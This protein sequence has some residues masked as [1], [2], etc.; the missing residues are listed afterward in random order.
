MNRNKACKPLTS[1]RCNFTLVGHA[2][3]CFVIGGIHQGQRI[4]DIE[5]YNVKKNSWRRVASLPSNIHTTNLSCVSVGN[6]IYI[7]AATVQHEYLQEHELA[8]CLFN[9]NLT[10]INIIATLPVKTQQI[11]TCVLEKDIYIASSNGDFLKFNTQS[12]LIKK[13]RRQNWLCKESYLHVCGNAVYLVGGVNIEPLTHNDVIRKVF[14]L[15]GTLGG[16]FANHCLGQMPI[17]ATVR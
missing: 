15:S 5:Q 10:S 8:I 1:R 7:F 3:S 6:V 2:G 16:N 11:R 13:L 9:P 17:Y 12:N 14:T 4:T